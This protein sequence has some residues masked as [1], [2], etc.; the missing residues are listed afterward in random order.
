MPQ[1]VADIF[2][3]PSALCGSVA[4]I[5]SQGCSPA[6]SL[7]AREEETESLQTFGPFKLIMEDAKPGGDEGTQRL[8]S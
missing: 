8:L 7:P 3:V 4:P 2:L 6:V 1:L 5:N